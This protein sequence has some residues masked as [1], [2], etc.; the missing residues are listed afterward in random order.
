MKSLLLLFLLVSS[1][2]MAQ[3]QALAEGPEGSIFAAESNHLYKIDSTT[4]IINWYRGSSSIRA[5]LFDE[6]NRTLWIGTEEG[7]YRCRNNRCELD[8]RIPAATIIAMKEKDRSLWIATEERLYELKN[9]TITSAALPS[10]RIDAIDVTGTGRV[11]IGTR[12]SVQ[13]FYDRAF[14]ERLKTSAQAIATSPEVV[15]IGAGHEL[16]RWQDGKTDSLPLPAPAANVRMRPPITCILPTRKGQ[17]Y[18][19]THIGLFTVSE[20]RLRKI[21]EDDVLAL[22]ED[23]K[24]NLWVGTAEGLKK[25]ASDGKLTPVALPSS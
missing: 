10:N 6:T 20:N 12:S 18:V 16:I 24:A 21:S 14:Q 25:M 15:W 3:I 4:E 11:W 5:L 2:V 1:P 22:L 17:V 7:L 19:G 23:T 9:D 13:E 8:S